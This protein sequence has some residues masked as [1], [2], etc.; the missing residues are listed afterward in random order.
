MAGIQ[1]VHKLKTEKLGPAFN[2]LFSASAISNLADGLLAVAAPLLAITLTKNPVLISMLSALV[3]LPWLLFAIPIGLIVDRVD[4]RLL[5]TFTNSLRFV[6]AGLLALAIATDFVTIYWLFLAAFLIGISE[7]ASDTASQSLIPVILEKKH[8]ERAN[9]R[10][11]IA[12]TVIQNFIGGPLSGF[13]YATAVVLPFV[14]NSAGFLI[15]A[16]F[17]FLIPAHLI[18]ESRDETKEPAEKKSFIG[19][20]KFGLKYLWSDPDLRGLVTIT[21]SLGFFYSLSMSTMILFITEVL[22]LQAKFFGVLMAGA[23]SG[24]II[25]ALLTPRISKKF[26]RGKVLALAIFMSSVTVLFQAFSPNYWVF[27]V[28]GFVSSFF[29][30]NWNILLMSCYQVLIP[31]ELYGRIHGARRTFVWGMMPLGA[32]LGGVIAQGGL[33]LPLLVGGSATTLI[34]LASV[35]FINRIGEKTSQGDHSEVVKGE[36]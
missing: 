1:W 6:I 17:V 9:S 20:I 26:G 36:N 21:T 23:G 24:A 15:A 31:K 2:R 7:V 11:N 27:G 13:L 35:R 3:M 25:G 28:V 34:S 8:F 33:R 14:L 12:E 10:L 30:T 32:F 5:I 4:K 29:I 16:I 18:T 22:G 19:D